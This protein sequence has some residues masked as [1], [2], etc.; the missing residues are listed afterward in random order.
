MKNKFFILIFLSFWIVSCSEFLEEAPDDRTE[1]INNRDKIRKLLVSAYPL[2]NFNLLTEL[3]SDN[4]E[5]LGN[6]NPH[7]ERTYEQMAYWQDI[8]EEN[9]DSP[10]DLWENCYIAITN[11][12]KV[13]NSIENL[14]TN[15][16]L[17]EK[18]EALITRAYSHFILVNVFSKH[19]N[20]KT[21]NT[22][23]GI[24]YMKTL[25]TT[26]NP[27]YER[28]TV[29][30]VY[31]QINNDIEE[32]LPL[33]KGGIYSKVKQYHFNK[34][35][36]YAFAARF[37]L[38]YGKW[39]KAVEYTSEVLSSSSLRNWQ[40]FK[41]LSRGQDVLSNHYIND[42]SNLL[43][44]TDASNLGLFF[45]PYYVGARFNHTDNISREQTMYVRTPWGDVTNNSYNFKPSRF[46]TNNLDKILF[47]KIPFLFEYTD[48]VAQI[49]YRR[50]VT[51]S[52]TTDETLLVRAEAYALLGRFDE[53]INDLN[54]WSQNFYDKKTATLQQV[55]DLYNTTEY[56]SGTQMTQKKKLSPAFSI[57]SGTQENLIH[58]VLQCR[59]ILTLHEGMRWFDI[60]RY[61]IEV[62]R[63]Q[64]DN[65]EKIVKETLTANDN[66]KAI[67][68]PQDV[69]SA[70]LE[71][72]PR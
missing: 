2:S 72:N 60:K 16:Y 39:Q 69:I 32:A 31:E 18:G 45:G 66:R 51:A 59:R 34:N 14:G 1:E 21:S 3:A 5:D 30:E 40:G 23:L 62:Y 10:K 71:A 7:S 61:G 6:S 55:N 47:L 43:M 13:L 38:Y 35:A 57:S 68:I 67:Q 42:E 20:S 17:V 37:N 4:I 24:P 28:G 53:A 25:E 65:G 63:I 54:T 33:L 58:Y 70:G 52:F 44:Q 26:L 36:A 27:K 29:K 11:S 46:S 50:T 15:D 48:P 22:D 41:N 64:M 12:N 49:G 9:N 19:Y 8:T 56:S